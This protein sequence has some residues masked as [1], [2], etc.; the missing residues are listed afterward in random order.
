MQKS[1]YAYT[2]VYDLSRW[3][4]GFDPSALPDWIFEGKE[5]LSPFLDQ[6]EAILLKGK[7]VS[8]NPEQPLALESIFNHLRVEDRSSDQNVAFHS[9]RPLSI[10]KEDIFPS[11][12]AQGNYDRLCKDFIN[13]LPLLPGDA[14]TPRIYGESLYYLLK[15]YTWCI[16]V[17]KELPFIQ[18]FEFLKIRA[19]LAICLLVHEEATKKDADLPFLLYCVDQ[20]GIQDFLYNITSNKAAKSLKGRSFYL[21]LLMESI[22]QKFFNHPNIPAGMLNVLYA[23]GGKMYFILPNTPA[24]NEVLTGIERTLIEKLY[25]THKTEIYLATGRLPFGWDGRQFYLEDRQD[26]KTIGDLWKELS[27]VTRK[28]AN[29]PFRSVFEQQFNDFFRANPDDG[30]DTSSG[31]KKVCAVTGETISIA[32]EKDRDLL[33]MHDMAWHPANEE[34]EESIWVTAPVKRQVEL[35]Y[36]LQWSGY[37]KVFYEDKIISRGHRKRLFSPLE[38]DVYHGMAEEK[39]ITDEYGQYQDL[40]SFN[41]AIVQRINDPDKFLPDDRQ[42][43]PAGKRSAYGFTFYGGNRQAY[44]KDIWE[45]ARNPRKAVKDFSQLAGLL[46]EEDKHKG[47]HRLG[48]LRMDVDGLGNIFT[49]GLSDISYL[50]AYATLSAE[51]DLFFS[52]Y[53]N[54]IRKDIT[55]GEDHLNI[56]YSGGDDV[57]AVGRWDV[58]LAFAERVRTEFRVFVN[59]REDIS[60]S[61]GLALVGP[62]FPIAKAAQLAGEAEDMAKDFKKSNSRV[63]KNAI[64]L[65]DMAISWEGEFDQ[66]KELKNE[67]VA[68]IRSKTLSA[69]FLQRMRVFQMT[70]DLH[71]KD[72]SKAKEKDLSFLW[73]SAYYISRYQGRFKKEARQ[74]PIQIFLEKVKLAFFTALENEGRFFDL[75]AVAARWAELEIRATEQDNND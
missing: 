42:N 66:V 14:A 22:K 26:P 58:A 46:S 32:D 30:F 15:K 50:P 8:F 70:K 60:I 17:G 54:T 59:G 9:F 21:Q 51:L 13:D 16:P 74:A 69:G 68:L 28:N 29:Q 38:L 24:V 25:K 19:A 10:R 35:G 67:M 27:D 56:I 43:M 48:V 40:P 3:I 64:V 18:L 31:I 4:K 57:F 12:M 61:A 41:F 52:G 34:E 55:N 53:I 23:S 62:K 73:T 5:Q 65:F 33:A 7:K 39:N 49:S 44:F 1:L 20:S 71:L 36:Q 47:F 45:K 63:P 2:L 72:L 6:A 75:I 11:E 37:Y